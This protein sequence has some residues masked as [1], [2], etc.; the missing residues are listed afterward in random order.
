[1]TFCRRLLGLF[2]AAH[3]SLA[4]TN[5]TITPPNAAFTFS[6]GWQTSHDGDGQQFFLVDDL[7][8]VL[9]ASFPGVSVRASSGS[10]NLRVGES[11]ANSSHIYYIGLKRSGGSA[12]GFCIDCHGQSNGSSIVVVDG[13]DPTLANETLAEQV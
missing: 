12:Y 5:L 10:H 3:L 1:M 8:A 4:A 6:S 9:S 2:F 11:L 7:G 13:N